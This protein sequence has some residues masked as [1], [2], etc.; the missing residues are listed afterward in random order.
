LWQS[1]SAEADL[2]EG[3][4][5]RFRLRAGNTKLDLEN[6]PWSDPIYFPP[7]TFPYNLAKINIIGNL[8]QVEIQF[9][10]KDKKVVPILKTLTAKSKLI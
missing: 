5:L 10:T 8:L 7:E 1:I 2:P 3:T 6:A 9:T 4:A